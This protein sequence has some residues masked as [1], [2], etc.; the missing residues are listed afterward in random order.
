MDSFPLPSLR[1]SPSSRPGEAVAV[2]LPD[3]DLR[4]LRIAHVDMDAFFAS[5]EE[6]VRPPL[7]EHP[8]AVGGAAESRHGVAT[9]ANYRARAFGIGSG[10]PL[11]EANR[12]CPGLVTLPVD[13]GK[14]LHFSMQV[15]RVLDRFTPAVEPTSVDEAFLDLTGLERRWPD[16]R[17]LAAEL[18]EA[19]LR[20]VGIGAS[21]GLGPTKMIAKIASG[22]HKPAGLTVLTREG[23]RR[24]VG[25]RPLRALWGIGESTERALAALGIRRVRELAAADPARLH[26]HLGVLGVWL[27][28]S[29]NG[30]LD[31][32]V[33]PWWQ[34]QDPK[35][36]G[37]ERTLEHDL[38][39]RRDRPR[40]V[41][42]LRE[43]AE[44]VGRRVREKGMGGRTV[45][46]KVRFRDFT[47][48]TRSL[49]LPVAVDDGREIGDAA[50]F[51]LGRIS[52]RGR[53][54]RLLGV[55]LSKVEKG[56]MGGQQSL[57]V[58]AGRRR[59]LLG[60]MDRIR[61][62]WGEGTIGPG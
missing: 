18:Q 53:P 15:L 4:A 3:R 40:V 37:H 5:V 55:S 13:G 48:P 24:F 50:V 49:T 43:L 54:I 52:F 60:V 14:Y 62:K 19:I 26:E 10:M 30:E 35:S 51:L 42:L 16:P 57:L 46:L 2:H 47:T 12:R 27:H 25:E 28:A 59:R 1:P 44:K 9:T 34:A 45:T 23:F 11:A 36:F 6:M 61:D 38:H 20:E 32:P 8:L 33:V 7:A 56:S 29:A 39:D 17:D 21:V 58:D 41:H 31:D 22:M